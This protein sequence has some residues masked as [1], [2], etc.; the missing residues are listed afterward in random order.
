MANPTYKQEQIQTKGRL[1]YLRGGKKLWESPPTLNLGIKEFKRTH[2][3]DHWL[4]SQ[5]KQNVWSPAGL[6][7]ASNVKEK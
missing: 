1:R 2:K 6:K 5:Y 4:I 7:A 3:G